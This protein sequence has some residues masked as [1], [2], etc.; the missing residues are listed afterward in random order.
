MIQN[1]RLKSFLTNTIFR[2]FSFINQFLKHDKSRILL[3]SNLGF[4][5]NTKAIYDFLIENKYYNKYKIVCCT[6][7][8]KKFRQENYPNVLFKSKS[9]GILEYFRCNYVY[10]SFGKIPI[11][12]HRDQIVVQMWHGTPFKAPGTTM[13]KSAKSKTIFYTHAFAASDMFRPIMCDWF[14]CPIDIVCVNGH[15]RTDVFFKQYGKYDFGSY[16]KLILWTPTFRKSVKL[17]YSDVEDAPLVPVITNDELKDIDN[18]L[19][20]KDIKILIKLHPLQDL[21][22]YNLVNMTNLILMSHED[23][24]N[25]NLDLYLLAAQSDALITDYSS[26]FYD[27]LLLNRPIAF[28]EDDINTFKDQRGFSVDD[29]DKFRPGFKIKTSEGLLSFINDISLGKD[30]YKEQRIRIN[31]LVNKYQDGNN[32]KRALELAG[33]YL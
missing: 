4:R 27:Y 33:I 19:K 6:N 25:R 17:G 10:Y 29:P 14:L 1:Q 7:D 31:N 23:F 13:I 28:T 2:L 15:P 30:D 18:F 11:K 22:Q 9:S 5:D 12:P 26:I 8:Y 16:N 21:S 3:Y 32:S 24:T 20:E